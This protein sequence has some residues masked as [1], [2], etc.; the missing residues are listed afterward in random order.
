MLVQN[1]FQESIS[2]IFYACFFADIFAPKK[3]HGQNVNRENLRKALSY[4]NARVK[5]WWNWL[6]LACLSKVMSKFNSF[7]FVKTYPKVRLGQ[8]VCPDK[9]PFV[10]HIIETGPVGDVATNVTTFDQVLKF[11]FNQTV[12][13]DVAHLQQTSIDRL[14]QL[15]FLKKIMEGKSFF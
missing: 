4:E 9:G 1:W 14:A 8:W 6:Q 7:L 3:S 13:K 10:P 12:L 2:S 15:W 5:C 11:N